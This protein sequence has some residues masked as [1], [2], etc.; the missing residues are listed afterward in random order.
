MKNSTIFSLTIVFCFLVLLFQPVQGRT[1][2]DSLRSGQ[3]AKFQ[4]KTRAALVLVSFEEYKENF[5]VTSIPDQQI[6][7]NWPREEEVQFRAMEVRP[8]IEFMQIKKKDDILTRKMR[9]VGVVGWVSHKIGY[10]THEVYVPSSIW[11]GNE[12]PK[13]ECYKIVLMPNRELTEVFYVFAPVNEEDGKISDFKEDKLQA[14]YYPAGRPIDLILQKSELGESG[15]Y[16]LEVGA[17]LR[18]GGSTTLEIWFY[19]TEEN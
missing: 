9:N 16:Y 7:W 8:N 2:F 15:F 13:Y 14:G 19:H 17:S 10:E 4:F 1:A 5:D 12:K 3:E 18:G 11:D 6:R